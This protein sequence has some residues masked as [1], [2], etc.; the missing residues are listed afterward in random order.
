MAGS[1]DHV[2]AA[3]AAGIM[4]N[5]DLLVKLGSAGD[6]LT[7]TDHL[8]LDARL[9]I[10]FHDIPGKYLLNGC[11]ATSGSLLKWYVQQFCQADTIPIEARDLD[12]YTWLDHQAELIPAGSDGV[13]VLPYFLGEKTPIFDPQARGVIFGLTLFHTRYHIYRAILEAVAFG[14]RHHVE[15]LQSRGVQIQRV[16]VSEGG[17]RSSLWRQI[18]ADVLGT[19]V[20]YLAENPGAA[21]AVAFVAGVGAGIYTDWD[22]IG[23][24]CRLES[25]TAP[26][27]DNRQTYEKAIRS[28]ELY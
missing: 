17:A 22:L 9:F 14:F 5:G 4:N 15:V 21:L 25:V 12:L 8:V 7:S 20:S 27:P 2:A 16:V 26:N 28:T 23:T 19:P 18:L 24:F 10:D 6:I 1:A 3:L 11:M 13:V